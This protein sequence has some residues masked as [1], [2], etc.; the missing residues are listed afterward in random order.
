MHNSFS[1]NDS[2]VEYDM[3]E[4][5]VTSWNDTDTE[6]GVELSEKDLEA[7]AYYR[8]VNCCWL[9]TVCFILFPYCFRWII[10]GIFGVV[11]SILGIIGN[12]VSLLILMKR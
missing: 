8:L 4:S 12:I 2:E 1:T 6:C 10:H 9:E 5:L 11:L 3:N 7:I